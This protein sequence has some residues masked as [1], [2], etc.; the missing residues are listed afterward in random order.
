MFCKNCGK[1]IRENNKWCPYCGANLSEQKETDKKMVIQKESEV[2]KEEENPEVVEA[3]ERDKYSGKIEVGYQKEDS[4][5]SRTG[6]NNFE[7]NGPK[8]GS[9]KFFSL[10]ISLLSIIVIC[11]IFGSFIEG[12]SSPETIKILEKLL[13]FT[14]IEQTDH[15]EL[16]NYK[17][18][19]N[20]DWYLQYNTQVEVVRISSDETFNC[21]AEIFGTDSYGNDG[22]FCYDFTKNSIRVYMDYETTDEHV[23]IVE[24]YRDSKEYAVYTGEGK[25]SA[26]SEFEDA[27]NTGGFP[28]ITTNAINSFQ[29]DLEIHGL[30]MEDVASLNYESIMGNIHKA[31]AEVEK[32]GKAETKINKTQETEK[33]EL[34]S[35]KAEQ[36]KRKYF[37][38]ILKI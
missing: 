36:P 21:F 15:N 14:S 6:S 10:W 5:A 25:Y 18:H 23:S 35:S 16:D 8:E 37:N 24:Y 13:S 38:T 12:I 20:D 7:W 11:T 27:L 30:S 4:E 1:K 3:E 33:A 34:M 28:A 29:N 17:F 32:K 31:E 22:S 9:S 19:Y 2:E 26:S